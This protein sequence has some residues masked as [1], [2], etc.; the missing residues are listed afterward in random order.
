VAGAAAARHVRATGHGAH[1]A[2]HNEAIRLFADRAAAACPGFTVGPGNVMA[3]AAICRALDGLPLAIEL[4]AAWVRV[5]SV[6][7]ICARLGNRFALL[8]AGDRTA[9]PRQRTLRAT[10]EWSYALLTDPERTLFR[11]LSVF[12]GWSLEMAS[13]SAPTKA[14][15]LATCCP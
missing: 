12:A 7:Q 6:E 14:S 3:V 5:L 10:I 13:R 9:S 4:A 11:R 2:K 1:A 15:R 8:T